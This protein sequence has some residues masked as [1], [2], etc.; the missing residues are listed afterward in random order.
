MELI[1]CCVL[2]FFFFHYV[3]PH[4]EVC[5]GEEEDGDECQES[6]AD[7]DGGGKWGREL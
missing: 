5:C 7:F 1:S 6:R 2:Y 3:H 4:I